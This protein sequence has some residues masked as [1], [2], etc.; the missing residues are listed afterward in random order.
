MGVVLALPNKGRLHK[1]A[2][3]ILT[4][5]GIRVLDKGKLYGRTNDSEL[6]VIFARAADIPRLVGLGAADLGITGHDYVVEANVD[7]EDL[8]DLKFGRASLVLA[9]KENSGIET[10][11]DLKPGLKVAT[12]YVNIASRFFNSLSLK[13]E[14]IPITGAAEIMPH[15]NVADAIVDVSS[16]GTTLKIHGLKPI[17]VLLESSSRLIANRDSLKVKNDKIIEVKLALE[18]VL[19]AKGKKLLMMNVPDR[20]LNKVLAVLPAMAGPTV[21]EVRAEEKMW[22]VYTV[23]DEDEVYKVI[24]L[25]KKA[26]ARDLLVM[27]IERVIP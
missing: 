16:T 17:E 2:L 12:K 14:I 20:F 22:E 1:P 21:A 24:N 5:A 15:L 7:V 8:L 18:S 10:I 27:P 4:E 11:R 9:V 23:I 13:V 3:D 19:K 6:D 25:A 26:G